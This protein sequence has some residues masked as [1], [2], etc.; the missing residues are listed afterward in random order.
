[1]FLVKCGSKGSLGFAAVQHKSRG[2]KCF[3]FADPLRTT[4]EPPVETRRSRS[5]VLRLG[6]EHVFA[7]QRLWV[8]GVYRQ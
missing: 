5:P 7:L 4:C 8:V 2:M 1:M 6:T 3:H